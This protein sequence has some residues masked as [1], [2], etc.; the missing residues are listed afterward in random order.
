MSAR[1]LSA[2]VAVLAAGVFGSAQQQRAQA[3]GSSV[4]ELAGLWKAERWFGPVARG[5]VVIK[6]AGSTYTAD[7]I[8]R[9]LP[10]RVDRGEL[11]FELPNNQGRFRGKMQ[12]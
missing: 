6:R 8:G 7:M 10:V 3:Q 11:F 12:A 1:Q 4:D 2:I 5:P 9:A